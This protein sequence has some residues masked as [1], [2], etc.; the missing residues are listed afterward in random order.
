VAYPILEA[1]GELRDSR[2]R[3]GKR[4]ETPDAPGDT[5][6]FSPAAGGKV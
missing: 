3:E 1:A 4:S 6:L 5:V 2:L